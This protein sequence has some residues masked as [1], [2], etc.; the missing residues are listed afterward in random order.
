MALANYSDL[1]QAI[2]DFIVR[3]DLSTY[4]PN[5]IA[6]AE[7]RIASE[8]DTNDLHVT[9]TMTVDEASE[10]LP[11]D[12]KALI[13]FGIGSDYRQLDYLPPET[14]HST[15]AAYQ[16]S[17]PRA[18]TIEA[19]KIYF[20]PAPDTASTATYTYIAKPDIATDTTNRLMTIA[21]DIYLY[22]SLCEAAMFIQDDEAL[23]KYERSYALSL[24]R[25][26]AVDQ[27][28]GAMSIQLDGVV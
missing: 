19:N 14:F 16:A 2:A 7:S 25:L 13:R 11:A 9:T 18:Y 24:D 26:N 12:F 1:Q 28:K 10:D 8:L 3:D 21:P 4:I 5:F 23:V 15:F 27:N 20:A 17:R 22:A 6:L